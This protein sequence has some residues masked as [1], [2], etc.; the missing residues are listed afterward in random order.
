M[1]PEKRE[2]MNKKR[3]ESYLTKKGQPKLL[4]PK[5]GDILHMVL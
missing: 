1:P 4:E 2:E 3:R 5:N